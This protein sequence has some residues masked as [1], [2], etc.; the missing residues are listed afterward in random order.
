VAGTPVVVVATVGLA[1]P[2]VVVVVAV[3]TVVVVVVVERT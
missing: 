2:W 3:A 1:A